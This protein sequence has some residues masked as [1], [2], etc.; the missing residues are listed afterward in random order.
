M[1]GGCF[2][3]PLSLLKT[4]SVMRKEYWRPVVGYEGLYEVSNLGRVKSLNYN[5]TG[6]EK[7]MSPVV[8]KGYYRVLFNCRGKGRK[9][10]FVHRLVAE[11]FIPNP[12]N[13][14]Q[15]NHKDENKLN[16]CVDNLEWCTNIYNCN[17][18]TRTER[19]AKSHINHPKKSISITQYT[20]YGEQVKVWPSAAEIRR[21]L[22]HDD[23]L[24][25]RVCSDD[26]K[27]K[28]Y[29][30]AYGSIWRYTSLLVWNIQNILYQ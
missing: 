3:H 12:D 4:E 29:K 6:K 25:R 10:K 13:L 28:K 20:L 8:F 16:N 7:I 1:D 9:Q 17:Y 21:Q 30:T 23:N 24:I 26:P 18:G 15:V 22:G 2:T 14:P 27:Y 19:A 11:A 5:R